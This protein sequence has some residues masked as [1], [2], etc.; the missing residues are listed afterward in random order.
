[1]NTIIN[2]S[3]FVRVARLGSFSAAARELEQATS[4]I[5]KRISQLEKEVH[6]KLINRS[7][8]GVALTAA[9]ER[10]LPQFVRLLAAYEEVFHRPDS[11][12]R[13]VEGVR[14]HHQ[15]PYGDLDVSRA[16][17]HEVSDDPSRRRHG[18]GA[19]GALG[20]SAGRGFRS[21]GRRLADLVS[22]RHRRLVVPIRARDG[23]RPCRISTARSCRIT[24]RI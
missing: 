7:T 4:V 13:P 22:R 9:G 19:D 12:K 17:P 21:G 8:R 20:E 23:V 6:S 14:A 10:L 16:D 3:A 1:M 2:I 5:A 11:T 15:S 24:R 18:C